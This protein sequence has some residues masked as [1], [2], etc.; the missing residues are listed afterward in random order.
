MN[1]VTSKQWVGTRAARPQSVWDASSPWADQTGCQV[2]VPIGV[3]LTT[4]PIG[5]RLQVAKLPPQNE[6]DSA[7][8]KNSGIV[9]IKGTNYVGCKAE[10]GMFL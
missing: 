2:A 5:R 7:P 6:F 8:M 10:R 3:K 9:Q 4:G 1:H